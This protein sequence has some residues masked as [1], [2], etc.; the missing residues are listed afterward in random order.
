VIIANSHSN[1]FSAVDL[2]LNGPKMFVK[3][4]LAVDEVENSNSAAI[5]SKKDTFIPPPI[6]LFAHK[7]KTFSCPNCGY[8]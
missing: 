2:L 5:F 8:S 3:D 7:R 4:E 1:A 6:T